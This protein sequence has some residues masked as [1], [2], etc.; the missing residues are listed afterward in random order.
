MSVIARF[1]V[2]AD[3]FPLGALLEAEG[4]GDTW[5]FRARFPSRD[6]LSAFYHA[7]VDDDVPVDLAEVNQ[8][9]SA[10]TD[11]RPALTPAQREALQASFEAGYFDVPRRTTLVDLAERLDISDTALSQR[12]RRGLTTLLAATLTDDAS[13]DD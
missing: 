2:P 1:T 5:S 8:P 10:G 13:A 6:D 7:C 4:R 3:E 9:M 12:I 11:A